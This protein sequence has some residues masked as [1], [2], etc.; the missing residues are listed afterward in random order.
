MSKNRGLGKGLQAL[1]PNYSQDDQKMLRNIFISDIRV[2]PKQPRKEIHQDKLLELADSIKEHGV[3]QPII[4]RETS[5]NQYEIIAGER[6]WRACQ[7]ADLEKIPAIVTKYSDIEAAEIALIENLQR[8]N[9]NPLEEAMAY[10]SLIKEFGLTQEELSKR[11]GK[12]RSLITNM[13]RL[14]ALPE[15]ILSLLSS[16]QITT[17]HA[18]ALL[19]INETH[20]QVAAAKEVIQ[21]ELSVRDTEKLVKKISDKSNRQRNKAVVDP[22][23]EDLQDQL[24]RVFGTKVIIKCS[25]QGKG[26]LEIEFYNEEDLS[27][28]MDI[29]FNS[30]GE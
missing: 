28:I 5:K 21:K 2:N 9:L 20:Q 18:R 22:Q 25:K 8:E 30:Q 26:K 4:L 12:S 23:L 24:Q 10:Q 13:L 1:I 11:V 3:I 15:N 16:G 14:L 27:R 7:I 6:R 17:G 19:A 29:V